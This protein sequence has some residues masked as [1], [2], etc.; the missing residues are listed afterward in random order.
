M[1]RVIMALFTVLLTANLAFGWGSDIKI[2]D[3]AINCFDVDY[4][5]DGTIYVA[6]QANGEDTIRIY[7]SEDHGTTWTSIDTL[8]TFLSSYGTSSRNDLSRIRL[9]YDEIHSEL[10]AFFVDS[11]G[12]LF[13]WRVPISNLN[14]KGIRVSDDAILEGSFDVT[15]NLDTGRLFA[16]WTEGNDAG[17]KV[18]IKYSDDEGKHWT[19][20]VD[21]FW[22]VGGST[23]S[24]IT[25]GPPDNIFKAYSTLSFG[26][27]GTTSDLLDIAITCSHD[28]GTTWTIPS[29]RLTSNTY[30]D[31]DPRVCAANVDDSGVWVFYNRDMGSHEINLYYRYS[32]DAGANWG[33]EQT[34]SAD[35][36]ADEYI[37]D[38][39][40]YKGENNKYVNMVYIYDDPSGTPVRKAI[41]A[42]SSTSDPTNWHA[43]Q[44]VNDQDITPWPEDVAPRI[45]YSPGSSASGG[46][47]VFSYYGH[48]GLYFDSPWNNSSPPS[49]SPTG[50]ILVPSE[51]RTINPAAASPDG[52]I[53]NGKYLGFGDVATG[54]NHFKVEAQFPAYLKQSDNSTMAVKIFIAA[55]MPDDY[56]RLAYFDSSNNLKYQPPE[57]LSSWKNSVSGAVA[58]T[59][60]FP[61]VDISSALA[62][63]PSGTHYW[64]TLVVPDTVPDD[65]SGVNW[66]TT[67]WEITVNILE[68]P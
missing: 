12:Y 27:G 14:E 6:F 68:V 40:F 67:P 59:T 48:S 20:S 65:F 38:I 42:W 28:N 21:Y 10:F 30:Q 53:S 51:V 33:S 43:N 52:A 11:D 13:R 41:W 54:G 31:Y 3:G 55:Q 4:A 25:F 15:Y 61:E 64:Y 16:T 5:M 8:Y 63:I 17:D 66:A 60:I 56:S 62:N 34:L 37:A 50:H 23:R 18:Y 49:P 7:R 19:T 29:T 47:V 1:K 9:I 44:V 36:G 35:A 57:S 46:G 24:S 26:G 39:K 22:G 45:V 32:S 58:T 2:Y